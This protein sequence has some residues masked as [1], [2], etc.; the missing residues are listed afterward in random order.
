[1]G[2]C[3]CNDLRD[4]RG[5]WHGKRV[6]AA[7]VVK[8]G[9]PETV[10][11]KLAIDDLDT[12]GLHGTIAVDGVVAPTELAGIPGAEADKLANLT[13]SGGPIRVYLAFAALADGGGDA[14]VIVALYDD[15]RIE[16]RVL[17][18]GTKPLYGIFEMSQT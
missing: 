3:G 5:E 14:M 4:F 13:F 17:R 6:G 15:D 16:L 2:L 10:E 8:V 11:A 18:G 7:A 12:H 9:M 1:M